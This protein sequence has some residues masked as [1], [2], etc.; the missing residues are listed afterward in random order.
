M[1]NRNKQWFFNLK[2][3]LFLLLLFFLNILN[4][5]IIRRIIIFLIL[6]INRID[7]SHGML[8]KKK[9]IKNKIKK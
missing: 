9:I 2:V 8:I 4:I 6:I 5:V 7:I 1:Q 3:L